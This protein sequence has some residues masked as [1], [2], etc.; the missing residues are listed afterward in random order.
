MR[1]LVLRVYRDQS[2]RFEWDAICSITS[3][4]SP[5]TLPEGVSHIRSD[6]SETSL[7]ELL[8]G[9][10]A[11]VSTNASYDPEMGWATEKTSV[12]AAI[13]AGVRFFF[14]CQYSMDTSNPSPSA[15]EDIPILATR[16][17]SLKYLQTKQDQ[18]SWVAVITGVLFDWI[19]DLYGFG[20]FNLAHKTIKIFDG[21]N[22][23]FE[24]TTFSQVGRTVAKCLKRSDLIKNQYVYVNSF[25]ITQ[26]QVMEAVERV[27]GGRFITITE[28]TVEELWSDGIEKR[29]DGN[30]GWVLA[31]LAAVMYGK[32]GLAE[33]STTKG[34]WNESLELPQENLDEVVRAN[35]LRKK[36]RF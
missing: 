19:L 36:G 11:V 10:D 28:G 16:I 4:T 32:G 5:A 17:L 25:T 6:W 29:K 31:L 15:Q 30:F 20:G 2:E 24:A 7:Q 9:Q 1:T 22:I 33:Y 8:K 35:W 21:G 27:G 13:A 12:D 26:N 34:L 14:P 18:I 3:K 23:L